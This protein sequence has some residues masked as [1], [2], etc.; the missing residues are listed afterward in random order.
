M[1]TLIRLKIV[2]G[3][4]GLLLL[5]GCAGTIKTH[6]YHSVKEKTFN[7]VYVVAAENSKFI[8]FKPGIVLPMGSYIVLKDDPAVQKPVIGNTDQ[9]I[10]AELEQYGYDVEIVNKGDLLGDFD[11]LVAYQD[12]WR[13]DFKKVLDRLEIYLIAP[14]GKVIGKSL[15]KIFWNKEMHN[16]PTPK[17]EVPKMMKA[18][19][20]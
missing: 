2:I 13:W 19:L 17:K 14:D 7:K 15:Y 11:F 6:N 4:I 8:R 3:F 16:F 9:V 5:T 20:K 1:H 18:L 12:T 10:K